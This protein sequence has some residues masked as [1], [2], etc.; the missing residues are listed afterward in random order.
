MD[1]KK[2]KQEEIRHNVG[3]METE[4]SRLYYQSWLPKNFRRVM[5]VAHG[6]GEHSGRY[7]NLV[8][9]FIPRGYAIYA[10]DHRGHGR[11]SGI[12]GHV[13]SFLHYRDDL[14]T[15]IRKVREETGHDKVILVGHSMGGLISIS[16]SLRHPE[17]LSSLILSSPGLRTHTPPPKIKEKL[18]KLFAR[19]APTLLMNNEIDPSHVSRD[20]KVVKDYV[21]DPLV[22]SR[23]SPKFYVEFLR[24]TNR[25][26]QEAAWLSVPM[27]LLQAG[28]DRLVSVEANKEF[29]ALTGSRKKEL[30]V[31]DGHYHE[32][33][34]EPEKEQVF[35]DMNAWLGEEKP[36]PKKIKVVK[37]KKSSSK[38]TSKKARVVK[39]EK[40]AAGPLKK[41]KK[42]GKKAAGTKK[43]K[44]KRAK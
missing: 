14:A 1:T 38:G 42:P 41:A 34:N 17:T 24:E 40:T 32:I 27:L 28:D 43:K 26:L 30:K 36:Q 29:F 23:V 19:L 2:Q 13:N 33:F 12:R 21:E 37:K 25:V 20:P 7:G 4:G 3:Y 39:K 11:S 31:Y 6:L 5:V 44:K 16:Y 18:G 15:F 22:H 10:L 9:Y 8:E 35:E